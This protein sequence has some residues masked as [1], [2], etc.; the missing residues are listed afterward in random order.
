VCWKKETSETETMAAAPSAKVARKRDD[1]SVSDTDDETVDLRGKRKRPHVESAVAGWM[2][3]AVGLAHMCSGGGLAPVLSIVEEYL[4]PIR[5]TFSLFQFGRT[6]ATGEI[7]LSSDDLVGDLFIRLAARG[8]VHY[9]VENAQLLPKLGKTIGMCLDELPSRLNTMIVVSPC[10]SWQ[11]VTYIAAA[12][13]T[14]VPWPPWHKPCYRA[15]TGGMSRQDL[16]AFTCDPYNGEILGSWNAFG[17]GAVAVCNSL[18]NDLHNLVGLR[19][20]C[21]CSRGCLHEVVCC[22]CFFALGYVAGVTEPKDPFLA[23]IWATR[24]PEQ[25]VIWFNAVA[26]LAEMERTTSHSAAFSEEFLAIMKLKPLQIY[27]GR[28]GVIDSSFARVLDIV[29]L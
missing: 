23:A 22:L 9:I 6:G 7:T 27:N 17:Q 14:N 26:Y 25:H 21:R 20:P 15:R 1:D 2:A 16:S 11:Q 29:V 18:N 4:L 28:T 5:R 19:L 12:V 24:P 10:P 13:A 3:G 8:D